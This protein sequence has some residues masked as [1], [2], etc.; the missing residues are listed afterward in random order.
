MS[1]L[2]VLNAERVKVSTV[3]SPLWCALLA[4][5]LSVAV[6]GVQGAAA[7]EA[8]GLVPE[9]VGIGVAL[10]AVPITMVLSAMTFTGEYRTGMIRTTFAAT[11][12]RILV[13]GVKA[14]LSAA[15]SG[16]FA[17][18][19][20]L[21]TAAVARLTSD[22]MQIHRLSFAYSGLWRVALAVA[23]YAALA[24]VLGVAVGALLRHTAGAVALLLL[25]PLVIEPVV[26]N[27]P[28]VGGAAGPYLPFANAFVFTDVPW[29]LP[30]Y[31]MPWGPTGSLVYFAMIVAVV[32]A[33]AGVTLNR[34]DA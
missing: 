7:Y 33:A 22:S 32:F 11:P 21:A 34:R 25:W 26:G 19:L 5:V 6:A 18:A 13:L 31:A 28:N 17:G 20:V 9:R 15:L 1:A 10:F 30:G 29:L 23:V 12:N 4:A 14:V 3:R 27:L 8:S 16:A 24:A 2:A